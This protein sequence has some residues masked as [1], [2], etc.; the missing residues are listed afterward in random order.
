MFLPLTVFLLL[1]QRVLLPHFFTFNV[2]VSEDQKLLREKVQHLSGDAGIERM[3]S[4]LSE[5]RSRY[6]RVND[7]ESS[8]R[9]PVTP[10]MPAS[11]TPL[12]SAASSSERNI[13]DEGDHRTS[14]VVRSLFKETN[15]SPGESSFSA[16]RTSSDSQLGTSSVKLLAENEVLVNE[17]L[18]EHHHSVTDGFDVSDHIQNSIEVSTDLFKSYL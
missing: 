3:E 6:F 9:S 12:S 16:P 1:H 7:D 15:T 8:V 14:R 11:P 17:F 5:T 10:S 4:A 13:L 2:Q 18:H